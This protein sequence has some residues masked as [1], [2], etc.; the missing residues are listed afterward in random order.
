MTKNG[1]SSALS[2]LPSFRSG[3]NALCSSQMTRACPNHCHMVVQQALLRAELAVLLWSQGSGSIYYLWLE[4]CRGGDRH[5]WL[6]HG[7]SILRNCNNSLQR[8]LKADLFLKLFK[9]ETRGAWVKQAVC[10]ASVFACRTVLA[11]ATALHSTHTPKRELS[12]L[13]LLDRALEQLA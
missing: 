8:W 13:L 7:L 4:K 6:S 11:A 2:S 9:E 3:G 5:T 1:S 10:P 12:L